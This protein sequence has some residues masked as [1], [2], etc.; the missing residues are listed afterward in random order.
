MSGSLEVR[1]F[2]LRQ[3]SMGGSGN[4]A[5]GVP[6]PRSGEGS[7]VTDDQVKRARVAVACGSKDPDDCREL[8]EMLGL[9]EGEDGLPP[10]RR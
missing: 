10:V 5:S 2:L 9:I 8:L 3:D 1:S 7:R 4:F 6:A